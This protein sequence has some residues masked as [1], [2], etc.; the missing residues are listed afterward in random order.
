ML[1]TTKP[2]FTHHATYAQTEAARSPLIL[3]LISETH[4]V[5]LCIYMPVS[6]DGVRFRSIFLTCPLASHI[7]HTLSTYTS[8]IISSIRKIHRQR[9]PTLSHH[10]AF[11]PRCP[12]FELIWCNHITR[13]H[14]DQ[15]TPAGSEQRRNDHGISSS[16]QSPICAH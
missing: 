14:C 5:A 1:K 8:T 12:T 15:T 6:R 7:V 13:P 9:E 16:R 2:I 11:T 10:T 4:T 3:L